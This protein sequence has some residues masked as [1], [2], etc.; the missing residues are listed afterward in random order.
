MIFFNGKFLICN[1]DYIE[2]PLTESTIPCVVI[3]IPKQFSKLESFEKK[4][5]NRVRIIKSLTLILSAYYLMA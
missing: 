3:E 4:S 1:F 2:T 5:S